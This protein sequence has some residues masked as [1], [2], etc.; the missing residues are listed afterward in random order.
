MWKKKGHI[1]CVLDY[2]KLKIRTVDYHITTKDF[3]KKGDW[4][5][6]S[7]KIG[8]RSLNC[9]GLILELKIR[10]GRFVFWFVYCCIF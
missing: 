6:M 5:L 10:R 3:R 2:C 1:V 4:D 9:T 7:G 8:L